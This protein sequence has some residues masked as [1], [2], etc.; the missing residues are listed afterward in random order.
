LKRAV[1]EHYERQ[2]HRFGPTARGMDWKDEASQRLRFEVLTGVADLAGRTVLE[3]GAGAGHL[4]DFLRERG[5]AAAYAGID[6]S[7]EMVAAAR[8]RHPDVPFE[9]RDILADPPP[10]ADVVLCSGLFHVKLDHGEGEW[11]AFVEAMLR[12]M[13]E[14]CRVALAFNLMSDQVDFRSPSLFY[15]NPGEILD[16]CRRELGRFV[17]LRHDYPLHEFTVYVYRDRPAPAGTAPCLSVVMPGLNEEENVERAVGRTVRALEQLGTEFEVL[18]IDDGSTDRTGEIAERLAAEDRRVRVLRNERNLNYGVSLA[19]GLAAA[20]GDWVLHDGMDLPLAPEDIARIVPHL[21]DADI[22]VVRRT[23]RAAHSAWRKLT[24]W[25]NGLLLRTLFR[26]RASDLNFVQ[27]YRRAAVVALPLR[28]TSPAFVTP[29]LIIR[30]ERA[31]LRVREVEAE[32]RRREAGRAHF[33]KPR[34]IW[35]TLRDM[36]RLRL[37]TWLRGWEA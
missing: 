36:L 34:D 26:P 22:V 7:A 14:T 24:S 4:R 15:A 9:Q 28:S 27:F 19:R 8:R 23:D 12:R 20:R 37:R 10:P 6:L 3:I 33:G 11:R 32:F 21:V 13:F 16:F 2:L 5:V 1:V 29:E 18:V 30:A 35:W 17:A 25:T 31:G